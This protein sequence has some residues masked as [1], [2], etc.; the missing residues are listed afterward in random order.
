MCRCFVINENNRIFEQRTSDTNSLFFTTWT[1]NKSNRIKFQ[2]EQT[3]LKVLDRVHQRQFRIFSAFE[4]LHCELQ[5][6]SLLR[7]PILSLL[8]DFHS[9]YCRKLCREKESNPKRIRF[10][11][12]MMINVSSFVLLVEQRRSI[13]LNFLMKLHEY[14]DYWC[15]FLRF[16]DRKIDTKDERSLI[17]FEEKR[18]SFVDEN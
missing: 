7:K 2:R 18:N 8:E 4:E 16:E 1:K 17:F 3:N 6:I 5:L 12:L 10:F 13:F 14:F 9:W 15:E 11:L